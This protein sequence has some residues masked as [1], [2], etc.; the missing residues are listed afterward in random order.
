MHQLIIL[1]NGFDLTCELKS[2][3]F[4]FY[5]IRTSRTFSVESIPEDVRNA[6][7]MILAEKGQDDSLWCDIESLISA[8]VFQEDGLGS[9]LDSMFSVTGLAINPSS[10]IPFPRQNDDLYKFVSHSTRKRRCFIGGTF[11]QPSIFAKRL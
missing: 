7:D 1:G 9:R 2:K 6:W 11:K 5:G 4:D 10:T 8:C 3:F